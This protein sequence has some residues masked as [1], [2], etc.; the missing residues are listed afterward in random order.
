MIAVKAIQRPYSL[1]AILLAALLSTACGRT[2]GRSGTPVAPMTK[3]LGTAETP[4]HPASGTI[5]QDFTASQVEIMGYIL[6]VC[7]QGGQWRILV[8]EIEWLTGGDA[9]EAMVEA[10]LCAAQ[11]AD[12]EPPNGFFI[13]NHEGRTVSYLLSEQATIFMQT[14]SHCLDGSFNWDEQ[15]DLERFLQIFGGDSD[16]HLK[17]VPYQITLERGTVTGIQ[18]VYVP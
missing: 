5:A 18:E 10:G 1:C 7:E 16:S 11:E 14:L 9:A 8:D 3:E 4:A 13:R 12:C 2:T 17:T 6:N 15:I